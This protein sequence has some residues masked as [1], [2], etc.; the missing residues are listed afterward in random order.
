MPNACWT[1]LIK[2][3]AAELEEQFKTF[4]PKRS[5]LEGMCQP[6]LDALAAPCERA[7][8]DAKLLQRG[9]TPG[10]QEAFPLMLAAQLAFANDPKAYAANGGA[11]QV[12]K[13]IPKATKPRAQPASLGKKEDLENQDSQAGSLFQECFK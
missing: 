2:A 6:L 4:K 9:S 7:L 8:K 13:K 3:R 12:L 10:A 11:K 5:E 1:V